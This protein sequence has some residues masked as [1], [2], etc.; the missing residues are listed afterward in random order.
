MLDL[1]KSRRE[2][3]ATCHLFD[4]C[5]QEGQSNGRLS[6]D[7]EVRRQYPLARSFVRSRVRA[8]ACVRACT[9]QPAYVW[10]ARPHVCVRVRA[11]FQRAGNARPSGKEEEDPDKSASKTGFAQGLTDRG[12]GWKGN[13][14]D[15]G[16]RLCRRSIFIDRVIV[17]QIWQRAGASNLQVRSR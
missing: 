12:G 10:H 17:Q 6:K 11:T 4:N 15:S 7:N 13:S 8:N 9:L 1:K 14:V 2:L 3:N 16:V 5:D